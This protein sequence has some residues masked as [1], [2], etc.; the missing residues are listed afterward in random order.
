MDTS[1]TEA[2]GPAHSQDEE[3]D[4]R[5]EQDQAKTAEEGMCKPLEEVG[6]QKED[7]VATS[8]DND[9][10]PTT[11]SPKKRKKR[12]IARQGAAEIAPILR[13]KAKQIGQ[14]LA[15]T[16]QATPLEDRTTKKK[17]R[18]EDTEPD[19]GIHIPDGTASPKDPPPVPKTDT[20]EVTC[21]R[22]WADDIEEQNHDA[23]MADIPQRS[24]RTAPDRRQDVS[25][26]QQTTIKDARAEDDDADFF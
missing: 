26:R 17:T 12:R 22:D 23:E 9:Q 10:Q 18:N 19:R 4:R 5:A 2:T 16:T 3:T 14:E 21:T 6:Q 25:T 24:G 1:N 11:V 20:R 8:E 13:E 7:T 15:E